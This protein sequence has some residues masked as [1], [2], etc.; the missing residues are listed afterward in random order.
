M[1]SYSKNNPLEV[2][3]LGAPLIILFIFGLLAALGALLL[4]LFAASFFIDVSVLDTSFSP[5][6]LS[7]FLFALI[8]EGA[9]ILFF[10]RAKHR[11]TTLPNPIIGGLAFGI[12][13]ASLEYFALSLLQDLPS[14]PF[15]GIVAVHIT[16][17]IILVWALRKNVHR[18]LLWALFVFLSLLHFGYNTLL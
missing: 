17:S 8:E 10:L 9:K 2:V 6:H 15:F 5:S 7:L 4:E 14:G 1:N 18:R 13:F 11:L 16:T 12:G 3:P